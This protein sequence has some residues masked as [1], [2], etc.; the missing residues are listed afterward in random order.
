MVAIGKPHTELARKVVDYVRQQNMQEGARV[1]EQP[2]AD[3]FGVSRT[4]IRGALALLADRGL[5][6]YAPNQ[7]YSLAIAPESI[8]DAPVKLPPTEEE[9]LFLAVVRDRLAHR[10]DDHITVTEIMRRY[11]SS[12]AIVSRVLV[13]MGE[14]GLIERGDGQ[15]WVFGPTLDSLSAMEESYRFRELI[16]PSAVLEP[17]FRF[18][19][20][21]FSHIRRSHQAMFD[22]GIGALE[23]RQI[24]DVDAA[25][26]NAV[27]NCCGNR[28]LAQAIRQQT[29]LRRLS[30]NTGGAN[31]H[32]LLA[33]CH[34]HL[35]IMDM[36]E[37]GDMQL[38]SDALRRHI[39]AA[40]GHRPR[41]SL[42]GI[43]PLASRRQ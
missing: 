33:S 7:G 40:K 3:H 10:L 2:L 32:R 18:D 21:L 1:R 14:D 11:A 8:T 16:E 15:S 24:Y 22:L 34:E 43:P 5:L 25:F 4:P 20:H 38:A 39:N 12:R 41:V 29:T 23:A 6:R 36:I 19:P 35:T 30:E 28:F 42:R 17:G 31:R 9:Q 27:A 26:H 37:A 13:R